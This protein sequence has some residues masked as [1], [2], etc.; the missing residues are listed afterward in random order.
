MKLEIK[1]NA[2]YTAT[3]VKVRNLVELEG[4]DNLVAAP[5]LGAQALT[6]KDVQVGDLYLLFTAE[7]QLSQEYAQYNNLH[8]HPEL[9][10][11]PE[12]K[13]YLEDNRRVKAIKL[14]GHRSDALLMPLGSLFY[15]GY[16]KQDLSQ[17]QEGDSFDTIDGHAICNKY[18][19]RVTGVAGSGQTKQRNSRVEEKLFPRHF[20]TVNYFK[21]QAPF[22][23]D[24]I[25]T[26]TEKLHG[27][28]VRAGYVPVARKLSWLERMAKRFGVKVQETEYDFVVGSRNVIKDVNNT[29][30]RQDFYGSD[31]HS[32]VAK[33]HLEGL[34]PKDAIVYGEIIGYVPGTSK[35]IQANYTYGHDTGVATLHIYRIVSVNA[36]GQT[37]DWSWDAIKEFCRNN[38]LNYVP[39]LA[40]WPGAVVT[41]E[42]VQAEYLDQQ[43][44]LMFP[45]ALS[46]HNPKLVSEGVVLRSEGNPPNVLKAKSP[47]FLQHE[48]MLLD[49]GEEDTESA[50]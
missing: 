49:K 39:E 28:S 5:L 47:M 2:N 41:P 50:S 1:D 14:R 30:Y 15:L 3:V 43:L 22:K 31:V 19:L 18:Q 36:D 21:V 13:G 9:N 38:G 40:V 16:D 25:V 12:A 6:T 32:V 20:D 11:S 42:F 29:E 4:L 37:V 34:L 10:S 33:Q 23:Y 35:P 44:D 24:D 46:L 48:T 45:E 7:T 26:V 8:R 27:T 17:F